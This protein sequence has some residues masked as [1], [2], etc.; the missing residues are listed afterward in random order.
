MGACCPSCGA[1]CAAS[2]A[3]CAAC[4]ASIAAIAAASAERRAFAGPAGSA[5]GTLTP[6]KRGA[7]LI[8]AAT[9]LIALG[10]ALITSAGG[11]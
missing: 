4:G 11:K 1:A 8:L 9:F 10:V 7:L 5:R 2:A 6:K 3:S